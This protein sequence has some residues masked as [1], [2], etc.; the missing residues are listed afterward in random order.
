MGIHLYRITP[1]SSSYVD[2]IR[3]LLL[4][5][6]PEGY[7]ERKTEDGLVFDVYD[8]GNRI[9]ILKEHDSVAEVYSYDVDS[10]WQW[11][12]ME[13][14]KPAF[15]GR[16]LVWP[17]WSSHYPSKIA[18]VVVKLYDGMAFG[19]G[20]HPTTYSVLRLLQFIDLRGMSVLDVG[21]GSGILAIAAKKLGAKDVL[22]IDID[23]V[24]VEVAMRNARKN[25]VNAEVRFEVG[26]VFRFSPVRKWDVVLANL[27]WSL[28]VDV[29][30]IIRNV[31]R[32][33]GW[34]I[35]GGL[36]EEQLLAFLSLYGR[37]S[38]SPVLY[39]FKDGWVGVLLR[40]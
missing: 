28:L 3:L 12:W 38:F 33:G 29:V 8:E 24:A 13:D 25:K 11:R 39:C 22:G 36:L 23:E 15:V 7:I 35:V 34:L 9:E 26:D 4:E 5:L 6:F 10:S 1:K 14:I 27:V 31:V 16:V 32:P 30:E 17:T 2:E 37:Y 19:T 21:T 40:G 18:P 20:E